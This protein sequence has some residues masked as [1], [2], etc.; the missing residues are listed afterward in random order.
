MILPFRQI[1]MFVQQHRRTGAR[2]AG[3]TKKTAFLRM[4][5]Y[6]FLALPKN[7]LAAT[8]TECHCSQSAKATE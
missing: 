4:R 2:E 1:L 7:R 3:R 5:S 8:A 6:V